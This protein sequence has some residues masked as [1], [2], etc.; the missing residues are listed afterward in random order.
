M[1]AN[2]PSKIVATRGKKKIGSLSTAERGQL[3]TVE[4]CMNAVVFFVPPLFV[5]PRKRMEDELIDITLHL[6]PLMSRTKVGGCSPTSWCLGS[7]IS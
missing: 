3:V 6:V 5:F 1:V 2:R 7:S 4:I